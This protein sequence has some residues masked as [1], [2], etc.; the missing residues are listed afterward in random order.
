M[1]S[2]FSSRIIASGATRN[3]SIE[4]SSRIAADPDVTFDENMDGLSRTY[5]ALLA[6]TYDCLDRIVVNAYFRKRST[7]AL[8]SRALGIIVVHSENGKFVVTITA[9]RSARLATT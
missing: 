3:E 2:K 7:M 8:Q 6:G 5:E 1:R 9:A 4:T